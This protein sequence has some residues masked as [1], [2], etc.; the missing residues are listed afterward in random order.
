MSCELFVEVIHSSGA[1]QGDE[2]LPFQLQAPYGEW[3]IRILA[4]REM[5]E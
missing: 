5:I 3:L 2:Q 1:G 4:L